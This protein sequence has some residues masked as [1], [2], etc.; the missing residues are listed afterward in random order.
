MKKG[1]LLKLISF[2]VV[3]AL[4]CMPVLARPRINM[5]IIDAMMGD[6]ATKD[7]NSRLGL[8]GS[9][10]IDLGKV[11]SSEFGDLII[12]EIMQHEIMHKHSVIVPIGLQEAPFINYVLPWNREIH[13]AADKLKKQITS[14]ANYRDKIP[15]FGDVDVQVVFTKDKHPGASVVT[16]EITF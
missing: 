8:T 9:I 7:T 11:K 6:I 15:N 13:E 16:C 1:I 12:H 3:T 4:L 2:A 14:T 10:D 5:P